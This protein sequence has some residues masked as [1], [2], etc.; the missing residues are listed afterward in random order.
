MT[1]LKVTINVSPSM[2]N[3][4]ILGRSMPVAVVLLSKV[5]G[6][7]VDG[8]LDLIWKI[9]VLAGI[10]KISWTLDDIRKRLIQRPEK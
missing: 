7:R 8:T 10:V 2:A 6:D 4:P 5:G 3:H 9:F 1:S